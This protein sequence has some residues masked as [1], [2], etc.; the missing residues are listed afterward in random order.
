VPLKFQ[1][2]RPGEACRVVLTR[3]V[4]VHRR[5]PGFTALINPLLT[6]EAQAE[7]AA[8]LEGVESFPPKRSTPPASDWTMIGPAGVLFSAS[9]RPSARR[10]PCSWAAAPEEPGQAPEDFS[11]YLN[12]NIAVQRRQSTGDI[13]TPASS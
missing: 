11:S 13:T 6:P 4:P 5:Q 9:T 7:L 2:S 3:D 10:N 8:A 12:T 1:P